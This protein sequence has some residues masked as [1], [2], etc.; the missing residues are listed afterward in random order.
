MVVHECPKNT[1]KQI[2]DSMEKRSQ[3]HNGCICTPLLDVLL[4]VM[5]YAALVAKGGRCYLGA[6]L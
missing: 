2:V 4:V 6:F 3:Y 5:E 1:K